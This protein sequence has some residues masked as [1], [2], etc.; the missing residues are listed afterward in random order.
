M[1]S[2]KSPTRGI[3]LVVLILAVAGVGG[4]WYAQQ[5]VEK[6]VRA[7]IEER[8]KKE[9]GVPT[10]ATVSYS[11]L[12]NTLEI[13]D[14]KVSMAQPQPI[15]YS[16]GRLVGSGINRSLVLA[17]V[18]GNLA[19]QKGTLPV[20]DRIEVDNYQTEVKQAP[21]TDNDVMDMTVLV[22][23]QIITSVTATMDVLGPLLMETDVT[24][25]A[26]MLE[27]FQ[28]AAYASRTMPQGMNA[29]ITSTQ[30]S[31][32][33]TSGEM[34]ERNFGA[35]GIEYGSVRKVAVKFTQQGQ[36]VANITV[37]DITMERLF[38]SP[39]LL[40]L[41]VTAQ[42]DPASLN[43]ETVLKHAFLGER[44]FLGSFRLSGVQ[45][46]VAGEQ[47][48]F[49]SFAY[50]NSSTKPFALALSLDSL[51]L[52]VS[53]L[54]DDTRLATQLLGITHFTTSY[55]FTGLFPLQDPTALNKVGITMSAQ[56]TGAISMNI[57]GTL[58]GGLNFAD[59]EAPQAAGKGFMATMLKLTYTDTG[60]VPLGVLL[61]GKMMGLNP[62]QALAFV[63]TSQKA[64]VAAGKLSQA[65]LD[66]LM[67]YLRQPGSI[68]LT[69][70]PKEPT[71]LGD[72]MKNMDLASEADVLEV[73][74]G[75]KTLE[76]QVK[77]IQ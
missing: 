11:L 21:L 33:I 9:G 50:E 58:P 53:M 13:T 27:L 39:E 72:L 8:I 4:G 71:P 66:A 67:T 55:G 19:E 28:D 7:Q 45:A 56:D 76:E 24:N 42:S 70:T 22:P 16:I 63:E 68:S 54:P 35:G 1:S 25:T 69:I 51:K 74:K 26:F 23:K 6:Q 46:K 48:D 49:A 75:E 18:M 3:L 29:V 10:I 32:T 15:I 43:K 44:P 30:M 2:Q 12:A 41:L 73:T 57:E 60:L 14:I 31:G 47:I 64:K 61:A 17:A 20:I 59:L 77:A 38:F 36:E 52:P 37:D 40:K 62:G 34:E 5:E 65:K